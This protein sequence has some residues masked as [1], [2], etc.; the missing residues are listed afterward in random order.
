MF[1]ACNPQLTIDTLNYSKPLC[2]DLCDHL[3][4]GLPNAWIGKHQMW[5]LLI[6]LGRY[7]FHKIQE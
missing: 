7:Q 1:G 6:S 2:M 5:V 4:L 3:A